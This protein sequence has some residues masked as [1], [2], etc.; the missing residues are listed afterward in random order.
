MA[1][2]GMSMAVL[3][4]GETPDIIHSAVLELDGIGL[5][6]YLLYNLRA[7]CG[8]G[9][10]RFMIRELLADTRCSKQVLNFLSTT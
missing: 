10:D 7:C 1:Y 6:K 4:L 9:K 2:S 3:P 5:D 8:R